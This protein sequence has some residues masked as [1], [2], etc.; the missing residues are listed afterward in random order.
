MD[1]AGGSCHGHRVPALVIHAVPTP[2]A[3]ATRVP[4]ALPFGPGMAGRYRDAGGLVPAGVAAEQLGHD[5]SALDAW[6]ARS[7]ALVAPDPAVV[8][9]GSITGDEIPPPPTP[10]EL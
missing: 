7:H 8:P 1:R 3:G 2:P 6:A 4:G 5:R 10:Q 9:V